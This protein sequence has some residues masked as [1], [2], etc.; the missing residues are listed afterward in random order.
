MNWAKLAF[1]LVLF[2][3]VQSVAICAE[4]ALKS[5]L[6]SASYVAVVVITSSELIGAQG[7]L[8]HEQYFNIQHKFKP[9]SVLKQRNGRPELL[10]TNAR[11]NDP[12]KRQF[13][14]PEEVR[15]QPGDGVLVVWNGEG[16]VDVSACSPSRPIKGIPGLLKDAARILG[17][18]SKTNIGQ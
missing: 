6:E 11:F 13:V 1:L 17:G 12:L 14:H 7:A 4:R 3:P 10:I 18:L 15:L 5:D 16:T 8:R 2:A 9:V